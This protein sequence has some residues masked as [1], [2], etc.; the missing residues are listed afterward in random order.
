MRTSG[1]LST[2]VK[3]IL[4]FGVTIID[5]IGICVEI[6]L[7]QIGIIENVVIVSL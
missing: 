7:A 3:G 2:F 5:I 6:V 1:T 4:A